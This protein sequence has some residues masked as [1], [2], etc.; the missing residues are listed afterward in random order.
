V[1]TQPQVVLLAFIPITIRRLGLI[2]GPAPIITPVSHSFA[3][4]LAVL[5]QQRLPASISK[6]LAR[7][8]SFSES[9]AQ[10]GLAI[11]AA[12][13]QAPGIKSDDQQKKPVY[14]PYRTN[15]PPGISFTSGKA[16]IAVLFGCRRNETRS[17]FAY[18]LLLAQIPAGYSPAAP[19][20]DSV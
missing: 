8:W 10:A 19:R 14:L 9:L 3:F 4:L 7:R 15:R 1:P 17:A 18:S 6:Y 20:C 11:P 2:H 5:N 13:S 12:A 16:E